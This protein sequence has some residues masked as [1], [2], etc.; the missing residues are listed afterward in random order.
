MG[1]S[2]GHGKIGMAEEFLE[3]DDVRSRKT[4][5]RGECVALMP[6]SA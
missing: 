6:I 4:L 2:H 5:I 3:V 1:I